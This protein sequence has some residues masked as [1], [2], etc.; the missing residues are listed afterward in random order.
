MKIKINTAEK[1]SDLETKLYNIGIFENNKSPYDVRE[2]FDILLSKNNDIELVT[3]H[4]ELINLI[5]NYIYVGK[6]CKE[7]VIINIY[8]DGIYKQ[9]AY[10]DHEGFLCNGWILGLLSY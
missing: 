6:I 9:T 4:E 2:Y 10:Y 3:L 5:G 8:K 7:D 1:Y